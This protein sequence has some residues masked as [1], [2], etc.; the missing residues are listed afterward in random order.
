MD[1]DGGVFWLC[2]K[3]LSRGRFQWWPRH[4]QDPAV[5]LLAH[6]LQVLICGGDP[7]DYLVALLRNHAF[8]EENPEEWMPWNY[9]ETLVGLGS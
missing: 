8:V 2:Q 9:R 6:E 5:R 1:D 4:A 3:R 7:F